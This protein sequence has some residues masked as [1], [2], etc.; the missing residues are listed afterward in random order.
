M[1]DFLNKILIIEDE[2][3]IRDMYQLAF[4]KHSFLVET[5]FEYEKIF[6]KLE[7]FRPD[8]ILVDIMLP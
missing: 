1:S 7:K 2:E 5:V 3:D 8:V 4:E 6:S